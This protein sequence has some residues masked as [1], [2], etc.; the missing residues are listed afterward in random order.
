MGSVG[1]V[2]GVR[3][4]GKVECE[5]CV[6]RG[7]KVRR[8]EVSGATQ[9]CRKRER[10]QFFITFFL[11]SGIVK[12]LK[13]YHKRVF[14][15]CGRELKFINSFNKCFLSWSRKYKNFASHVCR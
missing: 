9:V 3:G 2:V 13:N 4:E 11:T 15:F 10:Y 7:G 1:G 14:S 12:H 6:R 8:R 5:V